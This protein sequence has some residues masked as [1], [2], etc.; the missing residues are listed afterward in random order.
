MIPRLVDN[1]LHGRPIVLQGQDGIHLNPIYVDDAAAAIEV[2]AG[3]EASEMI[4]VAGP[5]ILTL[6]EIGALIGE[7]TGRPPR[8]EVQPGAE[9]KHIVGSTGKMTRLLGVPQT[10]IAEGLRRMLAADQATLGKNHAG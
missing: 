1:V 3:L 6:R 10:G 9:P 2:A 7:A 8:F 4:N 5:Q